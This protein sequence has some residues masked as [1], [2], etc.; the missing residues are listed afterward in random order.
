MKTEPP[1]SDER[2]PFLDLLKGMSVLGVIVM[3][4]LDLAPAESAL[5]VASRLPSHLFRFAVPFFLGALGYLTLRRHAEPRDWR[6]FYREKALQLFFPYLC[7]ALIYAFDPKVPPWDDRA[8]GPWTWLLGY[9]ERHLYYMV[10]YAGFLLLLPVI[11]AGLRRVRAR[12]WRSAGLFALIAG[13]LALLA[14]QEAALAAGRFDGFYL[15]TESRLPLHWLSF[16]CAGMLLSLYEAE[17]RAAVARLRSALRLCLPLFAAAHVAASRAHTSAA[18]PDYFTLSPS[19]FLAAVTALLFFVSVHAWLGRGA[20]S[21]LVGTLGRRSLPIY[22]SHVLWMKLLYLLLGD[23]APSLGLLLGLIPLTLLLSLGYLPVHR[24]LFPVEP[25]P[26]EASAAGCGAGPPTRLV[27]SPSLAPD[28][29]E[30]L[31]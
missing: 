16:F 18:A 5:G 15:A 28:R 26:W 3:H 9:S 20:A 21:R 8:H 31:R 17:L 12:A 30:T 1:S 29:L 22:L 27:P 23:G 10:V 4:T 25:A 14:W 19:F 11:G 7:W 13:H 6:R 24:A 2:V